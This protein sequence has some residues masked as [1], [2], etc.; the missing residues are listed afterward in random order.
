MS[1]SAKALYGS[2]ISLISKFQIRYIG[3]LNNVDDVAQ[4]ITLSQVRSMGTEGRRGDL[5][6]EI[7][8][9]PE[10]Y[11]YINFRAGD[12]IDLQFDLQQQE[13]QPAQPPITQDP[14]IIG[15]SAPI[16][17]SQPKPH[18]QYQQQSR[19]Y[20]GHDQ[21]GNTRGRGR[22]RGGH[23]GGHHQPR[24]QGPI[25][26]KDDFDFESSNAKF[27]KEELAAELERVKTNV[28]LTAEQTSSEVTEGS[29]A[30]VAPAAPVDSKAAAAANALVSGET[31]N[32]TK[33]FFDNISCEAKERQEQGSLSYQE[34]R[35]RM[36]QERRTN[37]E[38][39]GQASSDTSRGGYRGRRPY[40][41]SGNSGGRGGY[42][43]QHQQ[44]QQQ[45]RTQNN[46]A[47][48]SATTTSY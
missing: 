11:E 26:S 1:D 45:R 4:I 9:T 43:Q 2:R 48:N 30:A 21:G 44:H 10:V 16:S 35:A 14:A 19:Q 5:A 13:E 22:G 32:K 7:P 37:L 17:A 39:F 3:I 29:T 33:S 25:I 27:H 47:Y 40:Y 8:E 46:P 20:G 18:Q 34:R 41:P 6:Q 38:T 31:Y 15:A 23:H 12:V 24:P 36:N 42:N 28:G